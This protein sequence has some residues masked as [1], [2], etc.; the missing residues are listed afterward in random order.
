VFESFTL[1]WLNVLLRVGA[2]RTQQSYMQAVSHN[3]YTVQALHVA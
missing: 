1:G 3:L 2:H